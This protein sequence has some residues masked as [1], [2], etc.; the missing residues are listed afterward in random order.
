MPEQSEGT[1]PRRAEREA[2]GN[3]QEAQAPPADLAE[4]LA[5]IVDGVR[6]KF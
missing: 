2:N 3:G 5:R 4:D 1:R 6:E